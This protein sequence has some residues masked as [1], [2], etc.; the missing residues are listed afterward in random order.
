MSPALAVA[1]R[2]VFPTCLIKHV[3]KLQGGVYWSPPSPFQCTGAH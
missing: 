2:G 1:D 3:K